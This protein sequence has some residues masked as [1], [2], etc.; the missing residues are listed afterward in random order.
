MIKSLRLFSVGK[1]R[2]FSSLLK[3][4]QASLG[5]M[6]AAG[7]GVPQ[8]YVQGYMWLCVSDIEEGGEVGEQLKAIA[9]KLS[10]EQMVKAEQLARD[11]KPRQ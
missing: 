3:V 5:F 11:W 6:Y 2:L 4:A 9:A 8:D 10:P 1:S 7:R